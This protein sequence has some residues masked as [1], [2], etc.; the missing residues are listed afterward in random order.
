MQIDQRGARPPCRSCRCSSGPPCFAAVAVVGLAQWGDA[1]SGYLVAGGLLY[2]VPIVLTA[3][4][5]VPRNNAVARLDPA[6]PEAERVWRRYL[7][8]WTRWNHAR[9]LAGAASTATLALA[10]HLG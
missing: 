1:G 9:G 10:L 5:H 6:A 3:A 7:Q 8:E 4:Y 2:A